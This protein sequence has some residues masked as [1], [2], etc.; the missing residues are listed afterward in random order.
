MRLKDIMTTKVRCVRPGEALTKAA[1]IMERDGIHH[2]VVCNRGRVVG[3]LS[4]SA[5]QTR[6]AEG[7]GRVGDAVLPHRVVLGSP[8]MTVRQAAHLMRDRP[9]SALPVVS[10]TRLVGIVTVSD[11]LAVLER[12][13]SR[14]PLHS[15]H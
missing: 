10:G 14:S 6:G 4:A 9:E 3:V 13:A 8:E 5:L 7:V 12:P 1:S 2:L 11:L 15:R